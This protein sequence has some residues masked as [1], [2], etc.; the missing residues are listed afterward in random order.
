MQTSTTLAPQAAPAVDAV[1]RR[2]A[3]R[4]LPFIMVC[5]VAAFLDRINI[6]FAKL[7][8]LSDLGF[9][10]AI[11]GLGAGIFFIGYLFFEVPSN[12]YMHRIGA[13]ATLARIMIIW[14][15]ISALGMF[16]QTPTEFYVQRF[17]LGA[18]E[19]GFYPGV[20]L[21]LTYW[22]PSA[23]RARIIA[24]FLCAIP[25]AGLI[26]GPL[27]GWILHAFHGANGLAG[28]KW[29]FLIEAIPS[30]VLGIAT[31]FYLDNKPAQASWLSE[32]DKIRVVQDLAEDAQRK[33]SF[34]ATSMLATLRDKFVL[35]LVVIAF[36]QAMGQYALSF[37]MPSLI[38]QAGVTDVLDIGLYTAIPY[39]CAIVAMILV[40]RSS[41]Q[42]LERRWHLIIPF[43]VG[44]LGI[45]ASAYFGQNFGL[46]MVALC[47]AAAGCYT[48][49]A[50][51]WNLPPA[52]L[53]GVGAAA[54][55]A[56]INSIGGIAGFL[57]PYL[58][59]WVKTATGSTNIAM[60]VLSCGLLV[61]A[62]LT[63][64]LPK[65]IVNR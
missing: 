47:V 54:G 26:G 41:D 59:G 63:V 11:F 60:Y 24:G 62:V 52:F 16:V 50:L 12:L 23:R 42:R 51:F 27:S 17:L 43:V 65:R 57:S 29:L 64:L 22:F 39:A 48:V 4:I 6:G 61:G 18:A 14:G 45:C 5:Y 37:W 13:K 53:E 44:A 8:M 25:L 20:I 30:V 28:W 15:V 35:L 1:Y 58:L 19:A 55:I 49:T 3:T 7:Q 36:F 40:G 56:I 2:I 31:L 10:D 38:K 21:Y 9:S 34:A 33:Q 32:E 46:A